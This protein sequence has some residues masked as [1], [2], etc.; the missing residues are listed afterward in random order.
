MDPS[1]RRNLWDLLAEEK[2]G[3]TILLTTHYMDEADILGDKIAILSNGD[4]ECM[5]SSFYLKKRYGAGY[6]LV[7]VKKLECDITRVTKILEQFIPDIKVESN[8]GAELTYLLDEEY[9]S[10]FKNMFQVLELYQRELL[11][12][13]FGVSL[14]TLEEVF[15]K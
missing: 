5:G 12:S 10:V 2:Y 1:A 4:L 6:R 14:T 7:C 15:M 13:S 9:T 8:V 3:R 11:I